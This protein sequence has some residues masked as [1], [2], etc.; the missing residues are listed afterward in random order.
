MIGPR[1]S[2]VYIAEVLNVIDLNNNFIFDMRKFQGHFFN[3]YLY[4]DHK[5]CATK[6]I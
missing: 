3:I 5:K 4:I 6:I 2:G 1:Y